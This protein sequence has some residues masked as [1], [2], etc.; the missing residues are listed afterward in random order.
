M[1][2]KNSDERITPYKDIEVFSRLIRLDA[3]V[4]YLVELFGDRLDDNMDHVR[5]RG[6]GKMKRSRE[7]CVVVRKERKAAG[8]DRGGLDSR[9][10]HVF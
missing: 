9:M 3:V 4:V 8:G 7:R 1:R 5:G 10:P 2:K 6:G